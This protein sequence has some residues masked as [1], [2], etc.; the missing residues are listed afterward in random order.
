MHHPTTPR[1]PLRLR[2]PILA[3]IAGLLAA[4]VGSVGSAGPAG[5]APFISGVDGD[6]HS[7]SVVE[8]ASVALAAHD[9]FSMTGT[10]GDFVAYLAARDA[11]ADAVAW[12][13]RLDPVGLRGAW[14]KAD[15]VHQEAVLTALAQLGK[16]YRAYESDPAVGFDCSGL[17]AFAWGRA[18][19]AIPHQSSAQIGTAADRDP[20]TAV[21]GDLTQYPGHVAMWLGVGEAIVHAANPENDVELSFN[22][23]NVRYGDP[24]G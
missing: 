10:P 18:G 20:S 15:M 13:M 12:E 3:G 22:R 21:A 19:V 2:R 9:T 1:R 7:T 14:A 17:T 23:R 8:R 5:A 6:H 24:T 16:P 11:A 4:T